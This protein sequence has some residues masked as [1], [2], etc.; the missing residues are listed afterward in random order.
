M[1]SLLWYDVSFWDWEMPGQKRATGNRWREP[2]SL[3]NRKIDTEAARV[4]CERRT[5]CESVRMSILFP[6]STP[7]H[8]QR[9]HSASN[10]TCR[11]KSVLSAKFRDGFVFR[12]RT[13][14][15]MLQLGDRHKKQIKCCGYNTGFFLGLRAPSLLNSHGGTCEVLSSATYEG[16]Q[17]G[18]NKPR[19]SY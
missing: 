17:K 2:F 8:L 16:R 14:R 4:K 6:P 7:P 11:K 9:L 3:H 18:T 10:K 19:S 1:L 5:K 13:Q 15:Q 12:L